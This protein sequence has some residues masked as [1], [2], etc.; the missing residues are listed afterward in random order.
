MCVCTSIFEN[1][2]LKFELDIMYLRMFKYAIRMR[3]Y[4]YD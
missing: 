4:V 2:K 3:L 1:I